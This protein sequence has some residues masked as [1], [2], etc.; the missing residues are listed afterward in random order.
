MSS[1]LFT[2][3]YHSLST[4]LMCQAL[5]SHMNICIPSPPLHFS[6]S[7]LSLLSL[8][9]LTHSHFVSF[10]LL[11]S[12]SFSL[13]FSLFLFLSLLSSLFTPSLFS[14][15]LYCQPF[16]T[17]PPPLPPVSPQPIFLVSL[18][19]PIPIFLA[20][21]QQ[22]SVVGN[23]VVVIQNSQELIEAGVSCYAKNSK[24]KKLDGKTA[25]PFS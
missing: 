22:A 6:P 14:P 20:G 17:S 18:N 24:G 23:M 4:I 2:F 1:L 8:L 9:L 19:S 15:S 11:S 12:P 25:P 10:S 16:K 5:S 3:S 7:L 21:L 13:Y